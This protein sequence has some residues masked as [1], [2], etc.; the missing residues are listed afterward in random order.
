MVRHSFAAW[1]HPDMGYN[2][3]LEVGVAEGN[4]TKQ[5]LRASP[6]SHITLID[7]T[8]S[9][10]ILRQME[11]N[12]RPYQDRYT[13]H[14][15]ESLEIVMQIEDHYFDYIY[16]DGSHEYEDVVKDIAAW[17]NKLKPGGVI[18]GHDYDLPGVKRAVQEFTADRKMRAYC[19]ERLFDARGTDPMYCRQGS[20]WWIYK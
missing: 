2:R 17:W 19:V 6:Y 20:D 14:N 15:A 1:Y 4:N 16:I 10:H 8:R 9:K 5:M 7:S 3:I 13:F 12:L 18:G 11:N